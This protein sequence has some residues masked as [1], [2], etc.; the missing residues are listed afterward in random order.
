MTFIQIL[1]MVFPACLLFVWI[2]FRTTEE[3][4]KEDRLIRRR[5]AGLGMIDG[6][7][8][9]RQEDGGPLMFLEN[10]VMPCRPVGRECGE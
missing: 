10:Y 7:Y 2:A 3:W 8:V 4:M 5:L 9:I 1:L 6:R